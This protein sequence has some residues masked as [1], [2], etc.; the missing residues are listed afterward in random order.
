MCELVHKQLQPRWSTH[1][2]MACFDPCLY[3]LQATRIT[4]DLISTAATTEATTTCKA[5]AWPL[6][7]Q[8]QH[9]TPPELVSAHVCTCPA[10]TAATLVNTSADGVFRSVFVPSPS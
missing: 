8:P 5:L 3:H 9:L 4:D 2:P 1:L 6:E 10:A 7:F